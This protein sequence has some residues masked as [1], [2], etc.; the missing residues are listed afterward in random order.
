VLK[1][2]VLLAAYELRR[3]T[4]DIDVAALQTPNEVEGVR[5]L[6][7]EV[8]STA[9]PSGLDDGLAFDMDNVTAEAIRDQE[10][11]RFMSMSASG[12]RSRLAPAGISMPRLLGQEPISLRGYPVEMVLAAKIVTALQCGAAS[13]RWRD[14]ADIHLL[15]G[16]RTF[17]AADVL[18]ALRVVA[19]HRRVELIGLDDVLDRYA[20]IGQPRWA[21]WRARLQLTETLPADFG[22]T[23]DSLRAFADPLFTGSAAS[24]AK[25][26]SRPTFVDP[27]H[28]T[29]LTWL[30]GSS[31]YRRVSA[32]VL[33]QDLRHNRA[34]AAKR[35][36]VSASR[37]IRWSA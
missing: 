15:T 25:L 17:R 19:V 12:T 34:Q 24:L 23:L 22:A 14:F 35:W 20:E 6:V 33:R 11:C 30:A 3:P 7:A 29:V 5:Q 9:L 21:S 26:A 10:E 28:L 8:A 27:H 18:Q 1:G 16:H 31:W 4:T 37:A 13:T 32:K 36:R 2:G